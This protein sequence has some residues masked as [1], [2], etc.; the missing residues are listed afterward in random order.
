MSSAP[1]TSPRSETGSAFAAASSDRRRVR[2]RAPPPFSLRLSAEERAQLEQ[3]AA[4]APLGAFIKAKLFDGILPARKARKAA[5]VKDQAALA[6]LLGMLGAMRLT[7][8]LGEIAKAAQIGALPVSPE[9]LAE[10]EKA[11]AAVVAMKTELMR[12]LG[13]TAEDGR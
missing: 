5:P 9:T 13:Y 1:R 6:Q 7:S 3:A 8:N 2:R 4:G 11:C 12:A 10:L